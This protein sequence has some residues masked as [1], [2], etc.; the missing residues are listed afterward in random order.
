LRNG[1]VP[2]IG[3]V[4]EE[5]VQL[6]K[7]KRSLRRSEHECDIP[8]PV[9]D[10]PHPARRVKI[11]EICELTPYDIEVYTDGS[12]VRGMVGAGVAIYEAKILTKPA[13]IS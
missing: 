11:N 6:Y 5:K 2:P 8:L 9:K 13:N 3:I 1:W 12:K 4:I 10:W 7:V